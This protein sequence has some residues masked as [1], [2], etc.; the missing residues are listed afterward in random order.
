MLLSPAAIPAIGPVGIQLSPVFVL[1]KTPWP[2]IASQNRLR[3]S[4][5]PTRLVT[6]PLGKPFVSDRKA[7]EFPPLVLRY[8]PGFANEAEVPA[9]RTIPR[10]ATEKT[11]CFV[12]A[13]RTVQCDPPLVV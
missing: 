8:N 7:N 3:S 11:S 9:R 4:G 6:T 1:V 5:S 13:F 2:G 12:K 10:T